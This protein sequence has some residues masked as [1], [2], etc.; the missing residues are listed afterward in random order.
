MFY[1]DNFKGFKRFWKTHYRT[2]SD[3]LDGFFL[4]LGFFLTEKIK[5]TTTLLVNNTL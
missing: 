1:G 3:I 2:L 4:Y 5:T